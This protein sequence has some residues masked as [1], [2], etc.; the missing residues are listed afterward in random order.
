[1]EQLLNDVTTVEELS[2]FEKLYNKELR[3]GLVTHK[4]TFEY[5][6]CLVRSKYPSDIKRGIN[7]LENLCSKNPEDKR[8]YIFYLAFGHTRLKDYPT[9]LKYCEGF[10][11]IEPNNQQVLALQEHCQKEIRNMEVTGMAIAGGATLA[12]GALVGLG[13]ALVKGVSK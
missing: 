4:T 5:A 11:Q 8:D 6:Y 13:Y 10:L 12:I 1:M 9:A 3:E 7:H 2:K